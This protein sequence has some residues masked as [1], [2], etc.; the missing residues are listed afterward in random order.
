LALGI[1]VRKDLIIS[2]LREVLNPNCIY[3]RSD[4]PVRRLEGLSE[5]TGPLYGDCKAETR[6][7]EN[8][9]AFW[10]SV[11]EGQ[12][13]GYFLDQK[14][15]RAALAPYASGA[16]VLDAFCY[17]GSFSVHAAAYGAREVTG[18][19]I[20]AEAVQM[21][22]RNAAANGLDK[23]CSFHQENGFDALRGFE[24]SGR[25]F[26]TVILAPPAFTKSRHTVEGALRGYKEINLR[27]LKLLESGGFLITCSCSHHMDEATFRD[28]VAESALD[29]H[30]RLREV[31]WRTQSPDHPI[32]VGVPETKYLKF[33]VYQVL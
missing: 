13:T 5:A 24:A 29:A 22:S 11:R 18:L 9:L 27:A 1:D 25:R 2:V 20:S 21:A 10:V 33:G 3:E 19:D 31:E 28:M 12:K 16:R 4:V 6:I 17:T 15:N 14:L 26:D 23:I 7:N 32:L 8:G 30:R